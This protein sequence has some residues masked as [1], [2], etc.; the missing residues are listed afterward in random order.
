MEK[1]TCTV[2]R[3][4]DGG[5]ATPLT[6]PDI[7]NCDFIQAFRDRATAKSQDLFPGKPFLVVAEDSNR[8]FV[9]TSDDASNPRGRKVVDAIWNFGY[10]DEV[11]RLLTNTINT[12]PGQR[13]R[14]ARVQHLISKDGVWNDWTHDFDAGYTDITCSVDYITSHDVADAPRLMNFILEP[15]LQATNL[16]GGLCGGSI[17]NARAA[18]DVQP[19]VELGLVQTALR[20]VFGAFAILMTSVG[21]PMWLAGEEFGDVHDTDYINVNAKQQDPV[22]WNRA[23]FRG[24]AEL[25]ANVAKLIQLRT[26]HPALQRNEVELFYTHPQFDDNDSPRVFAYCRSAGRS[27]GSS[28]QV[29]VIA[30]M[31]PQSFPNYDIPNWRWGGSALREIGSANGT[32]SYNPMNGTLSLSLNS[33][34]ARVFTT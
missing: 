30:N 24:N 31:G 5:N 6:R 19:I 26:S 11:R 32:P 22:Q 12:V 28:G 23:V 8:R 14:S 16:C 29:I 17:Q 34:A 27:L 1:F 20:R 2:L 21:M 13:S 10:R 33:F 4:G 15:M 7:N 3:G 18:I 9:T 25:M